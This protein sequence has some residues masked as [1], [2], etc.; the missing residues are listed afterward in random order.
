MWPHMKDKDT[1]KSQSV[2]SY[3]I[4]Y[5]LPSKNETNHWTVV[6]PSNFGIGITTLCI[7]ILPMTATLIPTLWQNILDKT[8][9]SEIAN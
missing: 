3:K 9:N 8:H 1:I 5:L 2:R 7:Y 4:V 6:E